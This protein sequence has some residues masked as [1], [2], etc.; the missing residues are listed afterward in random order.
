LPVIFAIEKNNWTFISPKPEFLSCLLYEIGSKDKRKRCQSCLDNL[1][2]KDFAISSCLRK[3]E[4]ETNRNSKTL[5]AEMK[6][7][8][9]FGESRERLEF[10]FNGINKR[11]NYFGISKACCFSCDLSFESISRH[12]SNNGSIGLG[13]GCSGTSFEG[14][15]PPQVKK[16]IAFEVQ[17]V[18]FEASNLNGLIKAI[19]DDEK[20]FER[21]KC[22]PHDECFGSYI[23]Q[24]SS[25]DD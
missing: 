22:F 5:H 18:F 6:M 11:K 2:Y 24:I 20:R 16:N 21:K 10:F 3:I 25:V 13:L 12:L 1:K 19:E 23:E 9:Y 17:K 7:V 8:E 14:I 15:K 4:K